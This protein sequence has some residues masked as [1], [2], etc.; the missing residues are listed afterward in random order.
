VHKNLLK[1]L[2]SFCL[3]LSYDGLTQMALLTTA[4]KAIAAPEIIGLNKFP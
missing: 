3:G 1:S 2:F 4:S